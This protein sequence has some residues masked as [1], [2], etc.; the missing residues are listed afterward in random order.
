MRKT[1]YKL[2]KLAGLTI[3]IFMFLLAFSGILITFR[4]ELLP[5]VYSDFRVIPEGKELHPELI[6]RSAQSHLGS[7]IVTNFYA[8]GDADEASLILFKDPTKALPGILT[9]NPYSGKVISEMPLWQNVFAVA[10]FF[11]ANFFLG[12]TG[13]WIVGILGFILF[14]FVITGLILW[15]PKSHMARKLQHTF[16]GKLSSQKLHHQLGLIL[17]IP[18]IVSAL[19]GFLTIFDLTY[20]VMRGI[21]NDPARPEEMS[22]IKV[23]DFEKD[24]IALRTLTTEQLSRLISIHLCG[25]KNAFIRVSYGVKDRHP[26]NGYSR[27]LI[28]PETQQIVQSFDSA[29][30]PASWNLK[31]M[32]IYPIHSGEFFGTAGKV[33]VFLGGVGLMLIFISGILLTTQRFKRNRLIHNNTIN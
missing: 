26:T 32:V 18:L 22:V 1:L 27:I 15:W 8:G 13:E 30:D 2:H 21:K 20:V 5:V 23:C 19:T 33:I 4:E 9:M 10:L 24:M 29:K 28:D 25:K 3:G 17:A 6:I 14:L 16:S 11:H 7:R 12:K 31:R